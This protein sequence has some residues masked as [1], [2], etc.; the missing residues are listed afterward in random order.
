MSQE[1]AAQALQRTTKITKLVLDGFKSFGKRTELLFEDGFN[2]VLGPNGSGKSN[3]L[4]ALCFVLGKSSSKSLRAEKSANLIYNGGKS[5][6]PSKTAEVSIFF[7]NADKLFP[8]ED[9]SIKISRIVRND[10]LSKYKINGKTHTRQEIIDLL[11]MAKI[12]PDGYNI[13]LQGDIIRLVE[14]SPIERRMIIEEI[15]GIG[16]YEEKKQQAINELTKVDEKL[17][18]AG[19]ILKERE[20]HLKELKKDRDQALKYKELNDKIKQNKASYLKRQLDKKDVSKKEMEETSSKHKEKLSQMQSVIGEFRSEITQRKDTITAISNEIEEKGEVEQVKLQKELEQMKVDIATQKARFGTVQQELHKIEQRKQELEHNVKDLEQR[21]SDLSKGRDE[22]YAEKNNMSETIS[23]LDK[24]ISDFKKKHN[25]GS[26]GEIEKRTDE[27][28]KKAEEKQKELHSFREQQQNLLREKDKLEFQLQTIDQQIEK[29]VSLEKEHKNE[30]DL[31]KKKKSEFNKL[32]LELNNLLNQDADDA[33]NLAQIKFNLQKDSEALAKAEIKQASIQEHLGA[34]I[35]VKK[36]MEGKGKLG[37]IYGTVSDLG[38]VESKYALALEV[39]ASQRINSV[40]VEDDSVAANCINFLKKQKLGIATFLPLNKIRG[41]SFKEEAKQFAKQK[42]I[43]GLAIDLISYD[44][45]F[46][47]VFAFVFGNTL[48]V[49]DIATARSIGVGKMRMVTLDG[50][51]C[52]I[53][54]AMSGG[55]RHKKQGAFRERELG[56]QLESLSVSVSKLQK[57]NSSLEESRAE[58]DERIAKLRELKA[59][60]EGD[61]IKTEKGLHIDSGDLDANK[62]YKESLKEQLKTADKSLRE[63]EDVL[64]SKTKELT[65]IKIERQNLRQQIAELSNPRL[66]AEL[67]AF[68]QKKKELSE[69]VI[70]LDGELKHYALQVN[71]VVGK[72]R[73]NIAKILKD[74]EKEQKDFS[75]EEKE[76]KSVISEKEKVVKS[77]EKEQQQFFTQFKALFEKRNKISDEISAYESKTLSHE[78]QARKVELTLNTYSIEEARIKA[79][80]AGIEAEY[81]QYEGVALDLEKPE[82]QLKKEISDFEKMM[83][84]IGSVNMRA[85]EIYET[86]EK[87]FSSLIEKKNMLVVEKDSVMNMMAEIEERKKELFV[88]TLNVINTNFKNIFT[89]LSTK[90][91]AFLELENLEKP[92]EEGLRIKVNIAGSKFLDIRSLSGGEKTMTALAFLFAIQEHEP[93]CFYIMDEVDAALDKSNS[94]K[95]AKLIRDYCKNAQYIVISHNDSL[96]TEADTLYGV[97]MNP[98]HGLSSVVSLK[99]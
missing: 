20:T 96:I 58:N 18:E 32:V 80:I 30:L 68:E 42:G 13:I 79:E 21:T 61:I 76:L 75:R 29:V 8:F 44:P 97:S 88:N 78:E 24:S 56:E 4:D 73:E 50:D 64:V 55:Y 12:N 3:I 33:K 81:A 19:I 84:N 26:S 25:L 16:A 40:V 85:L 74:M 36:I 53:S 93:A 49:E 60:L 35:A 17:N 15:A 77:K 72:D 39:A 27:L 22:I 54:G 82:E 23:Q 89:A 11:G 57:S 45:K 87:E 10:G 9:D 1:S 66:L 5:K 92:F 52:E 99:T 48:V 37:Q 83:A 31:L 51:L 86:V 6:N 70:K 98:D 46:R 41:K 14:M 94:S 28:D 62:S 67:N 7:D 59:N 34:N 63:L 91:D 71:D 95:L 43:Y 47:E 2:V 69:E 65:D 38:Q 90:G